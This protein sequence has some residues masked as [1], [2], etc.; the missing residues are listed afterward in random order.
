M[1]TEVKSL[2]LRIFLFMRPLQVQDISFD[3]FPLIS[4]IWF[5]LKQNKNENNKNYFMS[6]LL[7]P[8]YADIIEIILIK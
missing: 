7:C 2:F 1:D 6:S 3:F 5:S 8:L 4:N